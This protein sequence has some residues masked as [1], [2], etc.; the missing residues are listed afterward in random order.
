M[1]KIHGLTVLVFIGIALTSA[2]LVYRTK[3]G[4]VGVIFL[5]GYILT[6][7]DADY[8]TSVIM[9]AYRND[10]VKSVV[11]VVDSFGGQAN[12]VEQVYLNLKHLKTKK[13]LVVLAVN[14]LSGGY[15]VAVAGD[16][17]ISHPTSLIGSIGVVSTAP[18]LLIPSETILETGPYKHTGFTRLYFFNNLSRALDSFISSVVESRGSKLKASREELKRG[19]VYLGTEAVRIGLVDEIG[20]LERAIEEA[21]RRAGLASYQ[22]VTLYRP[23]G[24]GERHYSWSNVTV[25]LLQNLHPPPAIY[26]IYLNALSLTRESQPT[27]TAPSTG[28]GRAIVDLSHGNRASWWTLDALLSELSKRNVTIG[29]MASWA[30]VVKS[31]D[32]ATCLI[33]ALPSKPYSE[34]E[35]NRIEDFVRKGGVL[36]LIFDPSYE[37]LGAEGISNY[38][39]TPINS[40]SS[41]FGLSYAYGFLYREEGYYGIYRNIP[42]ERFLDDELFKGVERLV[43]F[44]A[45][46]IRSSHGVAWTSNSTFSSAAEKR[47]EYI[48]V[49]RVKWEN[50]TVIALGDT[51]IFSEPYSQVEDNYVFISNLA[52]LIANATKR[53]GKVDNVSILKPNLPVG[54]VKIYEVNEDGLTYTLQWTRVSELEVK[55]ERMGKVTRYF[56]VDEGLRRWVSEDAECTYDKPLPEPPYPLT[57]GSRW[58]YSTSFNL[59]VGGVSYEGLLTG[60]ERVE[61]FERIQALDGR[62]YF[63][64]KVS[65]EIEEK[66]FTDGITVVTSTS[67]FYWLSSEAGTVKQEVNISRLYDNSYASSISREM[68]LRTIR[69][70]GS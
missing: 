69:K 44:T 6:S 51:T 28:W 58:S 62:T 27:S 56:Y 42:V 67:G 12:Y 47:G 52:N 2:Y 21:G 5:R 40:I 65:V 14:A 37:Y 1:K 61:G 26:Y 4:F 33:V 13:P 39:V 22:V 25:G 15:Y 70:P 68:I 30:S 19:L 11:L 53:L 17:I 16:Y 7:G 36:L 32:N 43:F 8:Y 29:F 50:G 9:E 24:G 20:S 63:C 54:T 3:T 46:H 59:K 31:L 45:A 38:V 57:L 48:V 41:R 35:V 55:V 64:A 66:L 60:V 49:S 34:D 23:R 18:P 10:S